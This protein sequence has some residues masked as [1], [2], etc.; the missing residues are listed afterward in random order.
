MRMS[1]GML[2]VGQYSK[3]M[4]T[5]SGSVCWRIKSYCI[6]ICFERARNQGFFASAMAPWLSD[7][8]WEIF[9]ACFDAPI[10]QMSVLSQS[11]SFTA[12]VRAIYS[13]SVDDKATVGCFLLAENMA[14]PFNTKK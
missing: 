2:C 10:S 9:R 8:I 5:V 11:T 7:E 14:P 4:V 3:V 12:G 13:A 6:S 1:P